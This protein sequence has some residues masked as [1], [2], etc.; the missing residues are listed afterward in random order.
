[1]STT[2][3][4]KYKTKNTEYGYGMV[5]KFDIQNTYGIHTYSCK[6]IW[7]YPILI[8]IYKGFKGI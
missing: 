7:I 5:T 8:G 2:I 6:F 3:E 4:Y 1:M